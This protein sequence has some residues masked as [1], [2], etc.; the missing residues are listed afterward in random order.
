MPKKVFKLWLQ[1]EKQTFHAGDTEELSPEDYENIGEPFDVVCASE[2][3]AFRVQCMLQS[4]GNA[5]AIHQNMTIVDI[6]FIDAKPSIVTAT[7][8]YEHC[9][10]TENFKLQICELSDPQAVYWVAHAGTA[11]GVK[12]LEGQTCI[13]TIEAI[14]REM[15][16]TPR[17][18]TYIIWPLKNATPASAA[19][20]A[21]KWGARTIAGTAY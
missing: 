4:I 3:E 10:K 15:Y 12:V 18:C 20:W 1:V 13:A 17:G 19:R 2:N 8:T 14:W 9:G 5:I 21:K 16:A 7:E 6:Q 11:C